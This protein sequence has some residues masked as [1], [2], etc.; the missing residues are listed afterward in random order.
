MSSNGE[1]RCAGNYRR[2]SGVGVGSVERTR[3]VTHIRSRG[4]GPGGYRR[5]IPEV[6]LGGVVYLVVVGIH[7]GVVVRRTDDRRRNH[8]IRHLHGEVAVPRVEGVIL[9]RRRERVS[10]NGEGRCSRVTRSY[11]HI[12]G[13]DVGGVERT[14]GV[15]HIRSRGRAPADDGA[16]H[17]GRL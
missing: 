6:R 17:G 8:R 4:R 11:R 13:I 5:S 12:V 10:S 9:Q 3:G 16:I 14:R 1:G 7:V 15:T 2:V